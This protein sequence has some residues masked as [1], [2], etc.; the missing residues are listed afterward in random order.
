MKT[1]TAKPNQADRSRANANTIQRPA[2]EGP[3]SETAEF[4]D[5]RPQAAA[6]RVLQERTNRSPRIKQPMQSRQW[7]NSRPQTRKPGPGLDASRLSVEDRLPSA[8]RVEHSRRQLGQSNQAVQRSAAG[9]P[10]RQFVCGLGK[11]SEIKIEKKL[12]LNSLEGIVDRIN[13]SRMK[14]G[15][16]PKN[17][18]KKEEVEDLTVSD[19]LLV[20]TEEKPDLSGDEL[21]NKYG[22]DILRNRG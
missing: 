1:K 6:Q 19:L 20:L 13:K 21:W 9:G 7:M 22:I 17:K 5:N 8:A 11:S 15:W 2:S 10:V 18:K 12:E 4:P 16:P 14:S 3:S